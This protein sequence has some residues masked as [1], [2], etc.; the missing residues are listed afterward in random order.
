MHADAPACL[1]C[2]RRKLFRRI[3]RQT[4]ACLCSSHFASCAHV[5]GACKAHLPVDND[6][7]SQEEASDGTAPAKAHI[8]IPQEEG[9]GHFEPSIPARQA[10]SDASRRAGLLDLFACCARQ[11]HV[12]D[13]FRKVVAVH[14]DTQTLGPIQACIY[15]A[16]R[17]CLHRTSCKGHGYA[18]WEAH[19]APKR[20]S[21]AAL[22]MLML[23]CILKQSRSVTGLPTALPRLELSP[24]AAHGIA[25][26]IRPIRIDKASVLDTAIVAAPRK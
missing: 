16:W 8:S 1:L 25:S 4:L 7:H 9:K 2:R 15:F 11:A 26:P 12:E 20:N 14:Q 24:N 3:H 18:G 13:A 21:R 22:S 6:E 19:R 5:T 23:R 17:P 10:R